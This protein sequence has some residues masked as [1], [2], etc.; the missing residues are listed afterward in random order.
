MSSSSSPAATQN[1][2]AFC[3]ECGGTTVHLFLDGAHHCVRHD[4]LAQKSIEE[5]RK[6]HP[7]SEH[8]ELVKRRAKCV[9]KYNKEKKS[10]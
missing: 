10:N 7:P 1:K 4:S 2:F 5:Y 8:K 6:K 9:E 3:E